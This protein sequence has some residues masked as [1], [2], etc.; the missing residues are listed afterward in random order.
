MFRQLGV[1]AVVRLNERRYDAG[2]FARAG[3]AV[4]ELYFDD[5][6]VPP[7]GVVFQF[8]RVA[9]EEAGGG[10]VAVHCKAGLGRTGTLIAL[11]LMKTHRFTAREAMAWLRVARPGSVIGPQQQYLVDMQAKMWQWGGLPAHKQAEL[12]RNGCAMTAAAEAAE[13]GAEGGS[14]RGSV[15]EERAAYGSEAEYA[16]GVGVSGGAAA[17]ADAL[18]AGMERRAWARRSVDLR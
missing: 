17:M 13:A 16:A 10:A 11:W 2:H 5:C 14:R 9:D 18:A 12:L 8:F 4:R 6:T 1:R 15:G 3:M 7:L